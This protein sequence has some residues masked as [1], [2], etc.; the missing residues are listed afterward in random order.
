MLWIFLL[1]AIALIVLAAT[2]RID[3]IDAGVSKLIR[4][5]RLA[6]EYAKEDVDEV[7]CTGD[8]T[9]SYDGSW[10]VIETFH[11]G[12]VTIVF[13]NGTTRWEITEECGGGEPTM[14]GGLAPRAFARSSISPRA[15]ARAFP[16]SSS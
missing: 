8:T 9:F 11:D 1:L 4:R 2:N 14:T 7:E 6:W 16:S 12:M 13:E 5:V 3:A 10:R 15:V